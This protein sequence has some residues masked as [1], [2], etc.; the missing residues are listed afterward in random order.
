MDARRATG[1]R[2]RCGVFGDELPSPSTSSEWALTVSP[3]YCGIVIHRAVTRDRT[4]PIF[5]RSLGGSTN[6]HK[7]T[8]G[9]AYTT[10]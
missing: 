9:L 7:T 6:P 5:E 3:V 4:R 8:G 1:A 2:R 10:E